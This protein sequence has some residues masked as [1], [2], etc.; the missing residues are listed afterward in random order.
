VS[1]ARRRPILALLAVPV[2]G[3]WL[4]LAAGAAHAAVSTTPIDVVFDHDGL[5][6]KS[7]PFTSVDSPSVTFGNVQF[8]DP[9][10]CAGAPCPPDDPPSFFLGVQ[11]VSVGRVLAEDS[12]DSDG[13]LRMTFGRPTQ[14]IR[15]T[16][17][18]ER[19]GDPFRPAVS[20]VLTGFRT[21][22]FVTQVVAPIGAVGTEHTLVLQGYVIDSAVLQYVQSTGRG[23]A[24][25]EWVDELR[26]DPL[27]SKAGGNGNDTLKGTSGVDVLCGGPGVDTIN[28]AGG[29]DLIFGDLGNDKLSGAAG[30]DALKG[31][32]GT[33][34][35]NGGT[36]TDTAVEC[37]TRTSIP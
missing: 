34:A 2:L 16:Y 37:E 24:D 15:V 23:A 8:G 6:S 26:S 1:A 27:C 29:N 13:A 31:G 33:D 5:G 36:G 20:A 22:A 25:P 18:F 30:N 14:T 9:F 32:Q 17:S 7:A 28:G 4:V 3:A 10:Q 35:C 19:E 21:G 11:D 12:M